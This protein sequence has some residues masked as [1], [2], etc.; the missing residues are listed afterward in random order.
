MERKRKKIKFDGSL[1]F[2]GEYINGK[3]NRFNSRSNWKY[4][5]ILYEENLINGLKEGF[6][7]LYNFYGTII[8]ECQFVNDKKME[9]M[10]NI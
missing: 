10:K 7:S 4:K 1:K 9:M 8:F 2:K 5:E 6:G 3:I